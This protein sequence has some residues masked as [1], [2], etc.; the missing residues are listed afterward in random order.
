MQ[1]TTAQNYGEI[2]TIVLDSVAS[3]H[4]KR[5]YGRSLREFMKWYETLGKPGLTKALVNAYRA[6]MLENGKSKSAIN[7]ALSAIRKL[8]NEA[9]DNGLMDPALAAGIDRVKGV[10]KQGI[11]TGNWLTADEAERLINTPIHRHKSD[12]LTQLKAIRD[13]AILS[14]M[15]G[16][17]LRRSEVAALTWSQI[18][19]RDG[20]WVILNL[21]GKHGRVRTIGIPAWVKIALDKWAKASGISLGGRVFRSVKQG[22]EDHVGESMTDQAIY[23]VVRNHANHIGL[24]IAAHDT[25]RTAAA[26]ALKGGADIREI[27]Q[28]LGHASI[29]TTERYLEPIQSLQVTAGD[30]IQ[31]SLEH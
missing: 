12:K 16:A 18:Q 2:I 22:H 4:T 8:A 26:L 10:K 23:D 6:Q 7:Q 14:V 13:Q 17:A 3:Q 1:L 15:F 5:A 31:L 20:R 30:Y 25:R 24:T 21:E 28:M 27:Q 11:R 19:Q 9:A 29:M